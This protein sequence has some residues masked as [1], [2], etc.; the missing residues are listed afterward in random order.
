[1]RYKGCVFVPINFEE[2]EKIENMLPIEIG[3]LGGS[4]N[5]DPTFVKDPIQLKVHTPYGAPSDHFVIGHVEDKKVAFLARHGKGH[6]IPPHK[7][8]YRANI[9]G[10]KALGVTRLI[11]PGACGSLQ[12]DEVDVG[13]F[14][15]CDQIFDR[16]FGQR[17]DTFFEGGV[18]THIPFAHPFCSELRQ[19]IVDTGKKLNLKCHNKGTY[20]CINGPRF[21]TAAESKFYQSQ[22]FTVVG[23]TAYPE[24]ILAREAE[25]CFANI[26]MATD[27]DVY[28]EEPVDIAEIINVMN[29]NVENVRKLVFNVIPKI[30]KSRKCECGKALETS[31]I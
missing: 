28:G 2:K 23:M 17:A 1:M 21:S 4:G 19:I 10:F 11:S 13:D 9:W 30:P 7:I 27:K 29:Q 24:C 18:V 14:V 12:P 31:M 6:V 26:S 15:I 5:Y 22:N 25:I 20:V 3:V 16:T 8:N